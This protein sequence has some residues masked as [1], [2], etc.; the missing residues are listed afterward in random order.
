EVREGLDSGLG[1]VKLPPPK[2]TYETELEW[3]GVLIHGGGG[4]APDWDD[5]VLAL[6]AEKVQEIRR[7][8]RERLGYTCSAGIARNKILAK[9]GSGQNKPNNQTFVRRRAVPGFL[10]KFQSTK[11]RSLGPK[12]GRLI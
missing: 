3:K 4:E 10:E 5:V 11:L 12:R 6:A 9:L 2:W 1:D 8:V 7:Q